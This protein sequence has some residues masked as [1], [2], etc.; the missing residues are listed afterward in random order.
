[1]KITVRNFGPIR[2]AK[3]IEIKPMTVFVGHSNTGKSY[4]AM[5]IYA[6]NSAIVPYPSV[7]EKLFDRIGIRIRSLPGRKYRF[8]QLE[9]ILTSENIIENYF[10][11]WAQSLS[12]T[13]KKETKVCFGD[14]RGK[15]ILKNPRLYISISSTVDRSMTLDLINSKNSKIT[16]KRLREA[17]SDMKYRIRNMQRIEDLS[18]RRYFRQFLKSRLPRIIDKAFSKNIFDK[19]QFPPYYLP[20]VR[21]GIMQSHRTLG[22]A[23]MEIGRMGAI[24]RNLD[25]DLP[26]FNGVLADFMKA[27]LLIDSDSPS[28]NFNRLE[29]GYRRPF[30]HPVYANASLLSNE[31]E[32]KILQG[33]IRIRKSRS[34]YQDIRYVVKEAGRIIRLPLMSASSSVSELA[35]V[36]L[37]IRNYLHP[38]T[39]F[40]LEEP[41]S[42]LHPLAQR[43]ITETLLKLVN[44]YVNVL[45]TTHSD[46]VIDQLSNYVRASSIVEKGSE[47][48]LSEQRCAVYLFDSAG[49]GKG[50][51]VKLKHFE[52]VGGYTTLDHLEVDSS[53]YNETVSLMKRQNTRVAEKG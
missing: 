51:D 8:E 23:L 45:I 6:I 50:T 18:H 11:E 43:Q 36:V 19:Y 38:G 41:E 31:I 46:I 30:I 3:N 20:A 1:M 25:R 2:E 9:K 16:K 28:Y 5:L 14:E 39:T 22:I 24:F 12:D 21:G 26:L 17:A 37:F 52:P 44:S 32:D 15:N 42:H 29:R 49:V 10:F 13:W 27:L 33:S 34:G 48:Y 47:V 4:M 53:L 35:S 7:S 40:I